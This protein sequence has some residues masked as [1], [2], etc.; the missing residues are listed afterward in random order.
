MA[1]KLIFI[2]L[3]SG[4]ILSPKGSYA[5][6][7]EGGVP[8]TYI[9][10][11]YQL[12]VTVLPSGE[13]ELPSGAKL[14][15][16]ATAADVLKKMTQEDKTLGQVHRPLQPGTTYIDVDPSGVFNSVQ[17]SGLYPPFFTLNEKGVLYKFERRQGRN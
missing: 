1:K 8:T 3:M 4:V 16:T 2:L 9:A 14:P 13:V 15:S 11:T 7:D 5:M 10:R 17:H 12:P 6:D